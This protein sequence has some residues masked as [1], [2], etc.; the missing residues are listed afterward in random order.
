MKTG[1]RR[2]ST[3]RPRGH[4]R[5]RLVKAKMH[6]RAPG[7]SE[8]T[9][10]MSFSGLS[11]LLTCL[12]ADLLAFLVFLVRLSLYGFPLSSCGARLS[13]SAFFFLAAVLER[14]APKCSPKSS[15]SPPGTV[16]GQPRAPSCCCRY[17]E[18]R[19]S[20]LTFPY[21]FIDIF[22]SEEKFPSSL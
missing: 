20:D 5:K 13:S 21:L 12:L 6:E 10:W 15:Q 8:R 2:N 19:L 16:S 17:N 7:K 9:L 14:T 4:R 18:A 1:A 3:S 22:P 11:F